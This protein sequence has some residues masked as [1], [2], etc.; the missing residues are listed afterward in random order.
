MNYYDLRVYQYGN[1]YKILYFPRHVNEYSD[2]DIV[3][4]S[5]RDRENK[6]IGNRFASSISRTRNAVLGLGLCNE[7]QYF[8]T[9]TLDP[10][11]YNRYDLPAWRRDFS[12]WIRNQRRLTGH[13]FRYL[14][15]PE[16]HPKSGAWHMHGLITGVPWDYLQPFIPY[17]HPDK[18]WMNGY[19]YHAKMHDKFG[20]NSFGKIRNQAAASR[21]ALK[22]VAKGI[23]EMD[24]DNG[25]NLYYASQKLNR[26]KCVIEGQ[27]T[28]YL[29]DIDYENDFLASK[30]I[31][32]DELDRI[33]E[34]IY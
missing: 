17:V 8:I 19:R 30:W 26:P 4:S 3:G 25:V 28:S 33:Q 32:Q 11:K 22:Y 7:W 5:D 1:E 13:D 12:Q 34:Y 18:L 14:L 21:Y 31:K 10:Q 6:M 24:L 23:G 20:F 2:R 16:R 15:I 27:S 9:A 29:T